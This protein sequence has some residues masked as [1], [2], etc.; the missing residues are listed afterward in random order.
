MNGAGDGCYE[1]IE[2]RGVDKSQQGREWDRMAKKKRAQLQKVSPAGP[3]VAAPF[4][5]ASPSRSPADYKVGTTP[6]H[7]PPVYQRL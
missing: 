4:Q 6:S 3:T 7:W 2:D 5:P 1:H